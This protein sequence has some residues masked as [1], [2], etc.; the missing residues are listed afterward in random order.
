M[1]LQNDSTA[2]EEGNAG[3][4]SSTVDQDTSIVAAPPPPGYADKPT[5][6][7]PIVQYKVF[8][9][10][11]EMEEAVDSYLEII[12][13]NG[14]KSSDIAVD[15]VVAKKYG[16]PIGSWKLSSN[17]TDLSFLFAATRNPHAAFFNE[18]LDDW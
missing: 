1:L 11:I 14:G 12:D 2:G 13:N 3:T 17:V 18:P 6:T 4:S 5:A 8:E 9:S 7:T 15:S 10:R 16:Y